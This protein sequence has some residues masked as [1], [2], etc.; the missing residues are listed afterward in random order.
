MV[1]KKTRHYWRSSVI[2]VIV[3]AVV[4]IFG[5]QVFAINYD[6]TTIQ[7]YPKEYN[8]DG[9]IWRQHKSDGSTGTG[10]FDTFLGIGKDGT[11]KGYNTTGT[12]EFDTKGGAFLDEG[13]DGVLITDLPLVSI[14]GI[15]YRE[16]RLDIN[17]TNSNPDWFLS[18][19]RFQV[20]LSSNPNTGTYD[21]GALA[22]SNVTNKR[23]IYDID[24]SG[25]NTILMDYRLN[26]GSGW[27]DYKVFIPETMFI[28]PGT[29]LYYYNYVVLF[30]EHGNYQVTGYSSSDGFEEWGHAIYEPATKTGM[31]F[32]DLDADGVK[33]AGEPGLGGWTIYVD[34]NN[35]GT[36]DLGEPFAVTASDGTYTITGILPG[37]WRVKEVLQAG[38]TQSY[39]EL[40]YHEE[41]FLSGQTYANN[42]FGNWTTAT[43]SGM[44]F[45]DLDADGVK[46]AGEPGLSGWVIYVDYDNDG[47]KDAGEPSAT[48]AADGTYTII[49]INPGIWRVKEVAQAG[50]TQSFPA[51]GYHEEIFTSGAA[52][53]GNDFGN[54]TTATKSGMKFEDLDADGVKDAGEPGL[55]GWTIY[56]DYDNDG[57][58]DA[59]EPSAV[60]GA[61][62]TYQI[63]GI[64]PGTWR[65]KEVAQTDWTQSYPALG[66]HEE[67]FTSRAALTGNDFG[68]WTWAKKSGYKFLDD[69]QNGAFDADEFGLQGWTINLWKRNESDVLVLVATTLTD[70]TGYYEFPNIKPG[71]T[72]YVSEELPSSLWK[73]TYPNSGTTGA[74]MLADHPELGYVYEINLTS[75]E[76]HENNDFGNWYYHDETAWARD[77]AKNI[78]FNSFVGPNNWGWTNGPYNRANL[79]AGIVMELWAGVG[80]NDITNKGTLVGSF[81]VK[82]TGSILT[83]KYEVFEPNRLT[84]V[85][86]YIGKEKLPM[87]KKGS[88]I[89][90]FNS[91]G[92]FPFKWTGAAVSSYEFSININTDKYFRGFDWSSF[93]IAAHADVRMFE[94][95]D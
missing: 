66:Y 34:Y 42:N 25:D 80:Q 75:R 95:I 23:K 73:Q 58:L 91:P 92:Q 60:T 29:G 27:G 89:E 37:T 7:P 12:L 5:I 32:H 70:A 20:W 16:L 57:V 81:T 64:V 36:K 28:N 54:W 62:G 18:V 44:K 33:D 46:D 45:H 2:M 85:Q 61:G 21:Y 49:G 13:K 47:V 40:G 43:K 38:W 94:E 41:T 48:T 74:L 22:F 10:N 3:I 78:E 17:E 14:G 53:T 56:V 68:N 24:A 76:H 65:V 55:A 30:A 1:G 67:T 79:E 15:L 90:Y 9:V 19:D 39:P 52:L 86:F 84:T 63:T 82:L 69:N 83:A 51:L 72:Y 88:T 50:W 26:N 31:K 6:L 35:D 87:K 8:I 93:Y 59:G 4:A 77:P 11:E 71:V